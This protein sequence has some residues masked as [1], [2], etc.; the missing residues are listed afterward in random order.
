MVAPRAHVVSCVVCSVLRLSYPLFGALLEASEDMS[1]TVS[2]ALVDSSAPVGFVAVPGRCVGEFHDAATEVRERGR[3]AARWPWPAERCARCR[4][5]TG[6]ANRNRF[7]L[8]RHHSPAPIAHALP[9]AQIHTLLHTAHKRTS[10]SRTYSRIG[11]LASEQRG[12][13]STKRSPMGT[14]L[15][16]KAAGPGCTSTRDVFTHAL[17]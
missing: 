16:R 5:A 11:Y 3:R 9:H 15:K 13:C 8:S 4:R 7:G 6:H 1:V 12:D 2:I 10:N 17:P 14:C